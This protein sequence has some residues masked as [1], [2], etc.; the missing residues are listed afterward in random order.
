MK[1]RKAVIPAAGLGTRFLPA[2]KAQPKVMLPVIDVPAIQLVV[3]EAARAGIDD[4]LI[5][6]GRGQRAIED[7]FDRNLELE[8]FLE[9]KQKFDELKRIRQISDMAEVH[10]IRQK[11]AL[12]LGHAV[13]VAQA[14]VGDEPFVVMLGDDLIHPSEPLLGEMLR[15]HDTFGRS[16]IAAMEVSKQEISMYGCI[17][18][19][20]FEEDLVRILS[21]I[22]KPSPEEAPSNLA[23][24][25]RYVL[26]P[27]IFDALRRTTPGRGGEIQLTDA[28]N[29]LAQEQAVYAYRFEGRRFDVGNPL[30]YVKATVELGAE[31][32]DLGP[33]FRA[34]L[35]QYV[36]REKLI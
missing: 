35:A 6:T 20:P 9:D 33:E 2:T 15:A 27:E 24:I 30:D 19:E 21:I 34:W 18:P 25:G 3:E 4:V 36:Q 17:Q 11:E 5:V 29:L 31:R 14:H 23:V 13:S 10:Y 1:V 16:V 22:E 28:I 12:G 7:H 26:T 32:D 8:R